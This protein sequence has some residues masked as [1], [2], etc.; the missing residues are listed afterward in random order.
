MNFFE[1]NLILDVIINITSKK[2][3]EYE[4]NTQCVFLQH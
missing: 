4:K 1:I 3:L 2:P